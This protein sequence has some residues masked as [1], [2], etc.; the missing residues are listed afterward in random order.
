MS[1]E[2][3]TVT[4]ESSVDTIQEP[5]QQPSSVRSTQPKVVNLSPS[6][7]ERRTIYDNMLDALQSAENETGINLWEA[8]GPYQKSTWGS[9]SVV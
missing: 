4:E 5:K 1:S 3:N 9:L 2:K 8:F 7:E 6:P